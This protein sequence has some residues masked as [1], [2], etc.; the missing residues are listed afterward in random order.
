MWTVP[1][2]GTAL[3]VN[4]PLVYIFLR[5]GENGLE[6]WWTTVWTP[7][8]AALLKRTILLVA[9]AVVLAVAVALPAAWLVVRTD[10][11]GR[12]AWAVALALPLVVPSYVAAYCLVAVLGP[13]GHLQGLLEPFGVE[14]L[15]ELAY[16]YSGALLALGLYTYPYVYLLLVAALAHQDPALEESARS[17]GAGRWRSFR[18]VVLPQ[19]RGPIYAGSLLVALYTL[20]D[21]GAVSIVRYNTFTLAIYNAYRGLFDRTAAAALSTVLVV[22]TLGLIAAEAA[23]AR[24]LRPHRR[25]PA[26]PP[27]R[28]A[29]GR[30]RWPATLGLGSFVALTLGIPVGVVGFWGVRALLAGRDLG[31]VGG[32]V[33]A[34]LGVAAAAAVAAMA[35]SLPIAVYS[36]RHPSRVSRTLE[37]LTYSGYALPGLVIALALVFFTVRVAPAL[38]QTV[39]L[40]VLAY[41]IRFLPQSTG[42]TRATLAGLAPAFEEAARSLGR[43][44]LAVLRTLVL[45]LILPGMLAGGA[46]V[47]LTTLKE[48][49]ATLLLRP[50]G[51]ETLATEIW[52]H[53]SEAIYSRAS[54]PALVLLLV[55]APPLYYLNIRPALAARED[56]R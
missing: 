21:F 40:L 2:L 49:P 37:R 51:F 38:Y 34:S 52:L 4:L 8:V 56:E 41:L 18:T 45:P 10:L 46:L 35:L 54:L 14:R 1:A 55:T 32:D 7:L 25:G 26:R 11:P 36:V 47:F 20:S 24:R 9:G 23:L 39:T 42:A 13:R 22:L 3:L 16:G 53:A 17:L 44:P 27:H 48:L 29:L 31:S 12:R 30:W 28:V 50:I 15:P 33:L 6:A 43:G 5:A 19:L